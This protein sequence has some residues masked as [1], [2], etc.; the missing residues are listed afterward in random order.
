M[1]A[2]SESNGDRIEAV[3]ARHRSLE[4]Y[5]VIDL[6]QYLAGPLCTYMLASLG[7]TVIKVEPPSGDVTRAQPPFA[8]KSGL[9]WA[10]ADRQDIGL[11]YLKRNAGKFSITLDLKQD[12]QLRTFHRLIERADACVMNFRPGVAERLKVDSAALKEINPQL[13]HCSIDGFGNYTDDATGAVDIVIQALSGLMSI[14]GE[15]AGPPTRAGAPV[16]DQVAGLVATIAVLGGLL[17]RD[18][19]HG[20]RKGAVASISMLH[21]LSMLVWDEH[22]DFYSKE[23]F[24][25][26]SGSGTPRFVPF[27]VY[28]T[29]DEGFVALAAGGASSW[30]KLRAATGMFADAPDWDDPAA[31]SAHADDIN[32]RLSAWVSRQSRAEVVEVLASHDIAVAPVYDIGDMLADRRFMATVLNNVKDP[33]HGAVDAL[34]AHF[35]ILINGTLAEPQLV[36]APTLDQHRGPILE[37]LQNGTDLATVLNQSHETAQTSAPHEGDSK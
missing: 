23:G 33:N 17:E 24:P 25:N 26:R 28:R 15:A 27:N 9:N 36:P 10:R 21:A 19:A 14:T 37:V 35:P 2:Y 18:G 6:T 1:P 22:L 8:T 16:A 30:R 29:A 3:A 5:V 4:G 13:V 12:E 34:N 11:A 7:A 20:T 32:A 31:R